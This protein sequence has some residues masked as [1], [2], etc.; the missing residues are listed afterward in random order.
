MILAF[1][2]WRQEDYE[3]KV[4]FSYVRPCLRKKENKQT[5]K[6]TLNSS[7]LPHCSI[8]APRRLRQEDSK[9]RASLSYI[10]KPYFKGQKDPKVFPRKKWEKKIRQ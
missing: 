6:Q 2:R 10:A 7:Q 5:K 8:P 3:V 1:G 4:I 9:L